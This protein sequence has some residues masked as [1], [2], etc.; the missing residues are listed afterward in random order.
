MH[1]LSILC[2]CRIFFSQN[3]LTVL[4]RIFTLPDK[5]EVPETRPIQ[6][7]LIII[8]YNFYTVSLEIEAQRPTWLR[9]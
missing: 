7:L 8:N 4:S 6:P 3:Q 5:V 2:W 9:S 1:T